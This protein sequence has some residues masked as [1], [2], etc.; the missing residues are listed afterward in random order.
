M[1]GSDLSAYQVVNVMLPEPDLARV[2]RTR[3]RPT[4]PAFSEARRTMDFSLV[5]NL[6]TTFCRTA[7]AIAPSSRR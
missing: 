1:V 3:F 4:P 7:C 5:V 2:T 6:R